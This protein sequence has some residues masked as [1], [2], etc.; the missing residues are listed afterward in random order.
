M[1]T[2]N[3]S[4]PTLIALIEAGADPNEFRHAAREAVAKGKPDFAYVVGTVRRRREEAAALVLHKGRM[5]NKQ[6]ALEEANRTATAGWKPP[7]LREQS[8]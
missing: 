2:A 8:A 1:P 6:E 4:H 5:P 3:P 7:E